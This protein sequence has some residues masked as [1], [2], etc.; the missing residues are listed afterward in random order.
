MSS[1]A[2]VAGLE[3]TGPTGDRYEEVLTSHAPEPVASLR[4]ELPA[5]E[6]VP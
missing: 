4:R 3:T 1:S 2:G 5:H 6:R